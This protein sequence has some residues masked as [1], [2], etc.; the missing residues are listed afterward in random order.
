[1]IS[2]YEYLR[3]NKIFMEADAAPPP[4]PAGDAGGAPP[5]GRGGGRHEQRGRA[6]GPRARAP[7]PPLEK[8]PLGADP[9]AFLVV[10]L[11]ASYANHRGRPC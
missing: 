3:K 6:L 4:P 9:L 7:R 5:P 10:S 2:I 11:N 1:M 8:T